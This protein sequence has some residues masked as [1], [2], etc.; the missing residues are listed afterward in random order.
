M[1]VREGDDDASPGAKHGSSWQALTRLLS[2]LCA[3][4]VKPSLPLNR[5]PRTVIAQRHN[6]ARSA[7]K[8]GR[9]D[10]RE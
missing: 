6:I 7:R 5:M 1:M 2:V 3:S 8:L 4:A 9:N 10:P